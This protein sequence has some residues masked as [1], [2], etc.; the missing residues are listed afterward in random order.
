[1]LPLDEC[2]DTL[3]ESTLNQVG[4][5]FGG[6]FGDLDMDDDDDSDDQNLVTIDSRLD[7]ESVLIEDIKFDLEAIDSRL[8]DYGNYQPQEPDYIIASD[9][10]GHSV[11]KAIKHETN[12]GCDEITETLCPQQRNR[13]NTWP[14]QF[15]GAR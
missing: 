3:M 14:R 15:Q 1:M 2:I 7:V 5:I 4:D 9:G 11:N 6:D 8:T 10:G 13:C 12:V